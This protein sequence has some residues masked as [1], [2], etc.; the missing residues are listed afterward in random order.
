MD[1]VC[2]EHSGCTGDIETLKE[3]DKSQ[4]RAITRIDTKL[5][6]I[7]G[8]ILLSPFLWKLLLGI[9]TKGG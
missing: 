1:S 9:S 4:W 2:K 8:A 3:S 5:N 6:M 7:I